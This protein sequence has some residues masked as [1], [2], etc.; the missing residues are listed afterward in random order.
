MFEL[1]KDYSVIIA[2]GVAIAFIMIMGYL[3]WKETRR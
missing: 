1:L 3:A 2:I